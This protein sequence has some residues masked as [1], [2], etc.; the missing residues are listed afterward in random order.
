MCYGREY[1]S[2]RGK[3]VKHDWASCSCQGR[4]WL[5]VGEAEAVLVCLEWLRGRS[6]VLR[7]SGAVVEIADRNFPSYGQIYGAHPEIPDAVF[8]AVKAVNEDG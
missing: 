8:A 1:V 4:G 6:V 7:L 2:E 5:P 3:E